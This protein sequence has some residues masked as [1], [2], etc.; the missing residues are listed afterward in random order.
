MLKKLILI[1][2]MF[3]LIHCGGSD[4]K[5]K[6]IEKPELIDNRSLLITESNV[7]LFIEFLNKAVSKG[8]KFHGNIGMVNQIIQSTNDFNQYGKSAVIKQSF[9]KIIGIYIWLKHS[10]NSKQLERTMRAQFA[11][12]PKSELQKMKKQGMTLEKMIATAKK[13]MMKEMKKISQDFTD[14]EIKT[15]KKAIPKINAILMKK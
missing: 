7:D 12:I 5:D 3:L 14:D 4:H 1:V 13:N 6:K 2:P 11:K 15:V 8:K 10:E 9:S